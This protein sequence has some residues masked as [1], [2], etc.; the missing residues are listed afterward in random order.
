[1]VFFGGFMEFI[2]RNIKIYLLSGKARSGKNEVGEIIKDYYKNKKC[3]TLSY[4]YYLKDYVKRISGWDGSEETKPRDLLQQVGIE[5]IKNKIDSN[6]LIRRLI[7]D[8]KVFS[9][10]YDVIII[11][12]ARLI[13]EVEIVKNEFDNVT[14]IR[15]NRN[16]DN[17]LTLE[18]KEHLTE[19]GLDNYNNFNYIIENNDYNTLKSDV[20]KIISEVDYE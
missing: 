14:T 11:T 4:S 15:V 2:K 9:H 12:D 16:N 6:L 10:F 5:L 8:I 7:E 13:D 1:V 17:D 18:Q 19:T 20:Y 3:I